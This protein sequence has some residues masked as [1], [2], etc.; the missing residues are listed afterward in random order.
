MP[1][2]NYVHAVVNVMTKSQYEA[3]ATKAENEFYFV[4]DED[5]GAE[6]QYFRHHLSFIAG[7]E[8]YVSDYISDSN[9]VVDSLQDLSTLTG[10]DRFSAIGASGGV[11]IVWTGS[12][13][14]VSPIGTENLISITSVSDEVTLI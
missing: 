5:T 13:W 9:L 2:D 8:R 11:E 10:Q 14:Q 3:L 7:G 6:K 12:I 4:T 1:A